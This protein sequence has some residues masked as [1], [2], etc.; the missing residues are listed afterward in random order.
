MSLDPI[1]YPNLV[2]EGYTWRS[3]PTK[4]YNCFAWAVGD[5]R[6]WWSPWPGYYWP[7]RISRSDTVEALA[8]AFS[9]VGYAECAEG[10][11]EAKFQ[12]IAIYGLQ[13]L[14][15]HAARQIDSRLWASKMGANIDIEHTLRAIEGP[16]YGAV[17]KFM[18]KAA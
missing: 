7:S 11:F 17:V 12:R 6:R 14:A 10:D 1:Q 15:K 18:K 16:H 5:D 3:P 4:K 8:E 13:G 2:A 9:T